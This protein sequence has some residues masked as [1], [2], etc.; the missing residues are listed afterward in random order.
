M[1]S[2]SAKSV[3][4][5]LIPREVHLLN[6]NAGVAARIVIQLISILRADKIPIRS[7]S[8]LA[9]S[10]GLPDN[11]WKKR[12]LDAVDRSELLTTTNSQNQV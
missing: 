10:A 8:R 6:R 3:D 12:H 2:L 9:L 4:S 1:I 11:L 7:L 5:S